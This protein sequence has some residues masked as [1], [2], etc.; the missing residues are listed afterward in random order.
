MASLTVHGPRQRLFAPGPTPIPQPVQAAMAEPPVYHRGPA[1]PQLLTGVLE[2]VKTVFPTS[3]DVLALAAS[4]TG[5]MEAAVVNTLSAGDRALAIQAGQF[6]ARWGELCRAYEVDVDLIDLPWGSAL[7]P[8]SVA[9]RLREDP[10]IR[11]VFATQSETSTGVL[12]DIRALGEVVRE[13]DRLL[14]VDGVSSVG[15]HPLPADEWGVD[16]VATASQKG[17]MLPPGLGIIAVGPRAWEAA[18]RSSLPR[19]YWDLEAYRDSLAEGRGPATLPVTLLAG[20]RAA[21]DLIAAEGVEQVWARHARHARAVR[22]AAVALGLTVFAQRPSNALTAIALPEQ[23]D[24]LALMECLRTR[25]G[26]ILGGGLA[27]LRGRV[28]RISNLGYVDDLDILSVVAALE[29]GL[30]HLDWMIQPGSG[31]AAAQQ[32]LLEAL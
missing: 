13:R 26:I 27:H 28:V 8:A 24:G 5:A 11:V 25:F 20:F 18:A 29:M 17:L 14:V 15:A 6:G 16:V 4:G 10:S 9:G 21:L 19:H 22:E 2:D 32:V 12:H 3:Y 31:V 7:D 1:F 23:V 30:R